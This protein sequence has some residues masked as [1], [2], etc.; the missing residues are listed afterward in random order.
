MQCQG[1]PITWK[2]RK[3]TAVAQSTAETEYRETADATQ[4]TVFAKTLTKKVDNKTPL[5]QVEN[6]NLPA[7][8]MINSVG[9]TKCFKF[10]DLKHQY[11][12]YVIRQEDIKIKH[13]Q[14]AEKT[15]DILT[16]PLERKKFDKLREILGVAEI[17]HVE[18]KLTK[19]AIDNLH[20]RTDAPRK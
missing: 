4:Y 11:I 2:S 18:E 16:N 8:D 13:K 17:T 9:A 19:M 5:K 20:E 6:D 12:K 15:A 14:S 3:Q 1:L 10:I 7:L